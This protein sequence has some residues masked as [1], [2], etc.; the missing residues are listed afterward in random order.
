MEQDLPENR[1]E[2]QLQASLEMSAAEFRDSLRTNASVLVL[3]QKYQTA[4]FG[5]EYFLQAAGRELAPG[6]D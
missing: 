1:L 4:C 6:A 2:E 5:K 3:G